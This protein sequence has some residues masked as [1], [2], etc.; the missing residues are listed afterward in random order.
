MTPP[1]EGVAQSEQ[2]AR[3]AHQF[4]ALC[5]RR[6]V[7]NALQQRQKRM[8]MR[9]SIRTMMMTMMMIGSM[10]MMMTT[11]A[12]FHAVSGFVTLAAHEPEPEPV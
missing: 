6:C 2:N 7:F 8:R 1:A 10:M 9:Q 3:D 12:T 11:T 5:L 4:G